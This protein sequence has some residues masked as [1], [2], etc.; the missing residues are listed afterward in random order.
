MAF[1]P[2]DDTRM[3]IRTYDRRRFLGHIAGTSAT[4]VGLGGSDFAFAVTQPVAPDHKLTVFSGSP[5]ERGRQYGSH[6]K[7]AIQ[8]FRTGDLE[9]VCPQ[10]TDAG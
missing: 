3:C 7:D 1:S 6:F 9:K 4:E 8:A 2:P 5:R 10:P